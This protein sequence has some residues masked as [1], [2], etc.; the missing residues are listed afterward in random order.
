MLSANETICAGGK[1]DKD[2]PVD[3]RILKL[4]KTE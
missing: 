2:K 4:L 1:F 3:E